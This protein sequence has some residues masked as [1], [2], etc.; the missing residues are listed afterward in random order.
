MR[1]WNVMAD[2]LRDQ[3]ILGYECFMRKLEIFELE[4]TRV[5]LS[6]GALYLGPEHV[7][8][9]SKTG[10]G[11]EFTLTPH[12]LQ[13]LRARHERRDPKSP[14]AFPSA[15]N[16]LRPVQTNQRSWRTAKKNA[17]I[18]GRAFWHHLRHTGLTH[19]ILGDPALPE[20]E[21]RKHVRSIEIV[22]QYAGVSIPV[23]ERTYLHGR[24]EHTASVATAVSLFR[25]PNTPEV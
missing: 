20:E 6:N 5:N 16:P 21:R 17:G 12:A 14:Y 8:T 18:R 15:T 1:L 24:K 25:T 13:R 19:A 3:F 23:L 11:R 9:G 22:S 2:D 10:K 7:K 4:W